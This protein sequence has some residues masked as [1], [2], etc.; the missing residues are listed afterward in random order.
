MRRP[1]AVDFFAGAGGMSLGFEQAGFD[2]L[3]AVEIDPIHAAVH[4]YNFPDTKVICD[5]ITNIT[6]ESLLEKVGLNVGELDVIF[7]GPPCQG[8]SLIGKRLIDDPRNSLVGHFS[9]LVL[10]MR[11]KYFVMEN[12]SGL[13]LGS[14]KAV[15]QQ[16]ID[17]FEGTDYEVVLPYKVLNSANYGVPQDRKRLFVYGHRK[18][19]KKPTYPNQITIMRHKKGIQK[20]N[21]LL[22]P[23]CPS[24]HDAIGDLPNIDEIQELRVSDSVPFK[25]NANSEYAQKLNGKLEDDSDFSY[26]REWVRNILTSSARTEHTEV[27]KNRFTETAGGETEAI[28]RF[29]KLHV[30]GICNTL[31]AGTDSKRGA[32]TSPRPI[33]PIYPRVISVREAARIHS[34]PDW[35]RFH[36]TKW[37]GFR[38]I[39]NSVPPLLARAV[40]SEVIKALGATVIKPNEVI[41]LGHEELLAFDM[42]SASSYFK[43]SKDVIGTRDRKVLEAVKG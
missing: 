42:S 34:Y 21:D 29:L 26:P 25:Y 11:P 18:D 15:L 23:L 14:A 3:A 31:R 5:D 28:S 7:G 43:V 22:Y 37:H 20:F 16:F 41:K 40:A 38:E 24:I 32:H 13:T 4:E 12:V 2:V 19:V 39:G 35:F 1:T 6:G 36:V 8:F 17:E 33:H 27:S 10:E 9:R 30:D